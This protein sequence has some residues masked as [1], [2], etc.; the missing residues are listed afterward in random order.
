MRNCRGAAGKDFF[1]FSK[2]YIDIYKSEIYVLM[3][4]RCDPMNFQNPFK[5]LGFQKCISVVKIGYVG[6]I[7]VACKEDKLKIVLV[8]KWGQFI[9][10][11][12]KNDKG[13]EWIFT[14]VY[15]SPDEHNRKH[16]WEIMRLTY[17]TMDMPWLVVGYF[18]DIAY[19]NEKKGGGQVSAR[20]CSIFG[21]NMEAGNLSDLGAKGSNY[22][23]GGPIYHGGQ[24]IYERLDEVI[25][26][27]EWRLAFSEAHV[28]ILTRVDFSHHHPIKISLSFCN[29]GRVAKSFR[30]ESAWMLE[31]N[32]MD[33]LQGFWNNN[34]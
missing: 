15:A 26:N 1:R 29:Y 9:H 21:E 22:T 8:S 3:V 24:R 14:M 18:N 19:A 25:R 7:I 6:G 12:V 33:R 5:K 20:K 4:I 17:A 2:Y 32:Y 30:F 13:Q 10:M 27:E 23:W 11:Q 16:L 31:E 34:E 28:K